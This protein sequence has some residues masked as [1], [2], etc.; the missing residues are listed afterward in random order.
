MLPNIS[1]AVKIGGYTDEA[2][3]ADKMHTNNS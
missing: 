3:L 1:L 2:R